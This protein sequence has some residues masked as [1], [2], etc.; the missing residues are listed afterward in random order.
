MNFIIKQFLTK[1]KTGPYSSPIKLKI[2]RSLT[3][4]ALYKEIDPSLTALLIGFL[5]YIEI[6][7]YKQTLLLHVWMFLYFLYYVARIVSHY[8]YLK[9]KLLSEKT[10]E[11][12]FS[13]IQIAMWG[14]FG[15]FVWIFFLLI[16]FIQDYPPE[17]RLLG[18]WNFSLFTAGLLLRFTFSPLVY[19]CYIIIIGIPLFFLFIAQGIP[20]IILGISL[21]V[22]FVFSVVTINNYYSIVFN[23]FY[24][25][26]EYK[27]VLTRLK[28]L[29]KEL[30]MEIHRRHKAEAKLKLSA[31]HDALTGL[32]NR[33]LLQDRV[34]QAILASERNHSHCAILFIDLDKFKVVND[35]YGHEIGDKILKKVAK[36]LKKTIRA[37]DTIGRIGGDEFI[38][39]ISDLEKEEN[40]TVIAQKI[41]KSFAEPYILGKLSFMC[42]ASIGIAI[43]PKGGRK[44]MELIKNADSAMYEAKNRGGSCFVFYK[45]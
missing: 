38:V 11:T 2:Y 36:R 13:A 35:D 8:L 41:I 17:A 44:H 16:L 37:V 43:F 29:N 9:S 1:I 5:T 23:S 28:K 27:R 21:M 42:S 34:N 26:Y 22:F 31:T 40:V 7:F 4:Q 39:L 3:D 18:V 20:F 33:L 25:Q 19:L 45:P 6:L 10:K 30:R 14:F 24:L 15:G 12:R 32:P